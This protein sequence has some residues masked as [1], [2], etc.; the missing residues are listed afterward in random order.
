MTQPTPKLS[1]D[2]LYIGDNGRCFCGRHAGMNAKFTGHDPSGQPVERV[3]AEHAAE[4]RRMAEAEG[5]IDAGLM[6]GVLRCEDCG[7]TA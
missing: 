3:T 4:Y 5:F 1:D 7:A 6:D 2:A